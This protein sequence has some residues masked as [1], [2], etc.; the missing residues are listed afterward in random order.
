MALT[1]MRQDFAAPFGDGAEPWQQITIRELTRGDER[2]AL[3]FLAMSAI[4]TVFM[5]GL[6]Q[7]NGVLSPRNRGSF[8][9]ARDRDGRLEGVALIGHATLVEALTENALIGF[10]RVARNCH[11]AHLIR[12]E[13]RMTGTFW[14]H[15]A[16]DGQEP[17]LVCGEQ[18]LEIDKVASIETSL[19]DL[20]LATIDDLDKI[21]AVNA[22]L[23]FEEG[24]VNPMQS[25]PTGFRART[26]NR[27]NQGRVWVWVEH[28]R[29][30]FKADVI[31]QT[32]DVSYLEGIYVNPDERRK[33]YGLQ[34]M[35]QLCEVLLQ[36]SQSICLTVNDR[37]KAAQAFY[38]KVGFRRHSDYR[39]IYLR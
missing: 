35:H 16:E 13:H 38:E 19:A 37:N 18:L 28:N 2:E 21:I 9:A 23:S 24:G 5:A 25:D 31:S 3:E 15:F 10:A 20:R 17:R 33:G 29:L 39:T 1:M 7:D 27:V 14:R 36:D 34:C 32:P 26:L 30:I 4:H 6:I 12:G 11:N 22:V 8:Y